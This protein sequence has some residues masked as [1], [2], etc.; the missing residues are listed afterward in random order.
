MRE[1]GAMLLLLGTTVRRAFARGIPLRELGHQL[2]EMGNRSLLLIVVG[3]ACFG[4][5]MAAHADHEAKP[6]IHD[7]AL[8][9][10]PAFHLLVRE[11]GPIL[12]GGLC[13][14]SL[15]SMVAAE[16]GTMAQGEQLEALVMSAGDP[17]AEL[18]AP[19]VLAAMISLPILFTLGLAVA[20]FTAGTVATYAYA[21]DGAAWTDAL[22]THGA[23]F[24]F[25]Y[26]KVVA[27]GLVIPLAG[28]VHGLRARGGASSVGRAVTAGAVTAFLA[29]VAVDIIAASLAAAAGAY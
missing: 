29:V 24:A 6:L 9:G 19:R 8:V 18:V 26:A 1:L 5:A 11:L 21:S 15:G 23:D 14:L 4:A 13:A 28:A 2:H 22:F 25:G 7:M 20:S 27:F 16:L 17:H 12:V 3:L 10:P